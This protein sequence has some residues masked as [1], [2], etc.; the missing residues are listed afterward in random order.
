MGNNSESDWNYDWY[1]TVRVHTGELPR[2]DLHRRGRRST[3]GHR[4]K[5]QLDLPQKYRVTHLAL[6]RIPVND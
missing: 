1:L 2:C 5:L 4:R 6:I 3:A